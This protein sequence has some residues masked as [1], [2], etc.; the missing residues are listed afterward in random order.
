MMIHS[1]RNLTL[2]T[3][4]MTSISC[5]EVTQ[6]SPDSAKIASNSS[7]DTNRIAS[8]YKQL[9]LMT[10]E[11]IRVDPGVALMCSPPNWRYIETA[12]EIYGPHTNCK[13][14]IYMNGLANSVDGIGQLYPIGAVVVK[15]KRFQQLLVE[16]DGKWERQLERNGGVA[17]MLKRDSDYDPEHQ[18]WEY[19]FLA[20]NGTLESGRLQSCIVCHSQ[21]KNTD[22]VFRAWKNYNYETEDYSGSP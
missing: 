10:P 21:A 7:R 5:T 8:E 19:F 9:T 12:Q 6:T 22:Y 17:G 2:I 4:V 11:P 13:V 3:L 16:N 1:Y 18:N 20:P 14:N 15:E